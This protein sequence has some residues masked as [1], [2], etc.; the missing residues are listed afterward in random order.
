MKNFFSTVVGKLP[1]PSLV[2]TFS[3]EKASSMLGECTRRLFV[4]GEK[5]VNKT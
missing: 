2:F 3:G 4:E 5:G 1:T